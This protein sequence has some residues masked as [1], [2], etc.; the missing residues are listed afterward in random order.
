M[1][2]PYLSIPFTVD[3]LQTRRQKSRVLRPVHSGPG[4]ERRLLVQE[5]PQVLGEDPTLPGFRLKGVRFEEGR[6]YFCSAA[7][8]LTGNVDWA[9]PR[10]RLV[11]DPPFPIEHSL[12]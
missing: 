12:R 1:Q 11:K 9:R 3:P 4:T 5:L 6:L 2:A 8:T 10:S 7:P